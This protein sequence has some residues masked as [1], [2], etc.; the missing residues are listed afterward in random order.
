MHPPEIT[1]VRGTTVLNLESTP[2]PC[3]ICVTS[4]VKSL[5]VKRSRLYQSSGADE[6]GEAGGGNGQNLGLDSGHVAFSTLPHN[7][8]ATNL[9]RL[10]ALLQW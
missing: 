7:M 10:D 5:G 2:A 9:V 8:N 3:F 1:A 6:R 4:A